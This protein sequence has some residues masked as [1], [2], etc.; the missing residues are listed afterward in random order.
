MAQAQ[1]LPDEPVYEMWFDHAGGVNRWDTPFQQPNQAFEYYNAYIDR[2]ARRET[3]WGVTCLGGVIGQTPRGFGA[4]VSN[5]DT[6]ML[7]GIFGDKYYYSAL[8]GTW[9]RGSTA[10][11]FSVTKSYGFVRGNFLDGGTTSTACLY[12]YPYHGT[13]YTNQQPLTRTDWS[14]TAGQSTG[15][16][17]CPQA[18]C[19]WQNRLWVGNIRYPTTLGLDRNSL[20]WSDIGN[21]DVLSTDQSIR[22]APG[23]GDEITGLLPA[24]SSDNSLYIFKKRSIWR[25][26]VAWGTGVYLPVTEDN[27]DTTASRLNMVAEKVGCIAPRTLCYVG[28]GREADVFFLSGDGVRSVRRVEQDVA[29]GA[30]DCVS[31]PIQDVM[32]R[33]NWDYVYVATACVYDNKYHLAVP[34]D[35]STTNNYVFVFDLIQKRWIGTYLWSV[36]DWTVV[37]SAT[38]AGYWGGINLHFLTTQ[39][40]GTSPTFSYLSYQAYMPDSVQ[41]VG[42]T[43]IRYSEFSRPL[44]FN[45]PTRTKRWDWAEWYYYPPATDMTV[46]IYAATDLYTG[47]GLIGH[48]VM[49]ASAT[50]A[51]NPADAPWTAT[52]YGIRS[53]RV[54][55]QDVPHGRFL[56]LYLNAQGPA[57]ISI[58]GTKVAARYFNDLWTE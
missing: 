56:Q 1:Q 49:S 18:A 3:R 16:T 33:I 32:A 6:Y 51:K 9:T 45:D 50:Y 12:I 47:Y 17:L 24:R 46:S 21:G 28:S 20:C 15:L 22:I 57:R 54:P 44:Y 8:D 19:W 40:Y 13:S 31:K 55:L 35:D 58:Y 53:F 5:S 34:L 14:S 27:I 48:Y 4:Y 43:D 39:T 10:I 25:L 29:G 26:D 52:R 11:S 7:V 23:D 30:G 38:A 2:V 37:G 36:L 42:Y 41:D